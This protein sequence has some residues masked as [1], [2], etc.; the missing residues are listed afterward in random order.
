MIPV[1]RMERKDF[2]PLPETIEEE[3]PLSFSRVYDPR[4]THHEGIRKLEA[5]I[6][7]HTFM[8]KLTLNR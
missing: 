1:K 7:K 6:E 3:E 8:G 5:F 2:L 4:D